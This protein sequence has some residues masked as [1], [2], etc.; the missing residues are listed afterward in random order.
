[1]HFFV[2]A[3]IGGLIQS[4]GTFVGRILI[5][6]GIGYVTYTALDTSLEWVRQQIVTAV[7]GLPAQAVAVLSAA[8][9]GSCLALIFSA[10]GARMLLDGLQGGAIKKMVQ[11]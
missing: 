6:L 8:N 1:M 9:V 5:S 11:K 7:G 3:L 10:I 4:A 2:A